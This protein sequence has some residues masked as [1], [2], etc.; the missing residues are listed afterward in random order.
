[1]VAN[2][3][4]NDNISYKVMPNNLIIGDRVDVIFEDKYIELNVPAIA[5]N[6]G[7]YNAGTIM[8]YRLVK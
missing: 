2:P 7:N 4:R 8:K 1:M 6:W 5:Y 3:L